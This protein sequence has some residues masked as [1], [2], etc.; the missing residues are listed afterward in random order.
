MIDLK[1][2]TTPDLQKLI[3]DIEVELK[4]RKEADR[5][6]LIEL[7][8]QQAK[9]H[10]FA[11]SDLLQQT[12]AKKTRVTTAG[13]ARYANPSDASQTWTGRGRKPQWVID[14]VSAG[15]SLDALLIK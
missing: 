5:K 8:A 14:F 10:G 3:K 13:T 6:T 4:N 7:F 12:G 15:G 11:L 9:D 1:S 2:V